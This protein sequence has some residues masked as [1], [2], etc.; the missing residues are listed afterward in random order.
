[1]TVSS[2]LEWIS[3]DL[4]RARMFCQLGCWYPKPNSYIVSKDDGTMGAD[5]TMLA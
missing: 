5:S 3:N 2:T 4:L 1:M